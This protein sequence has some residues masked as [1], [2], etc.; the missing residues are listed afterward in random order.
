ME[1]HLQS[2]LLN[3]T[4]ATNIINEEVIQELWSGYGKILRVKL[5]GCK[6][7][8]LIVKHVDLNAKGHHPRGWNT[9][10]SHQRKIESYQVEINWYRNYSYKS[11]SRLPKCYGA[12]YNDDEILILLEDL[13]ESGFHLRKESLSLEEISSCLKW[14]AKFHS[15][16]LGVK[17]EG[18]WETGSYWHLDTRP[19]E[20]NALKDNRLKQAAPLIDQVLKSCKYQTL[21]HGDAKLANFCFGNSGDVAAVDFQYVGGGCGMKDVAYFIGSVWGEDKCEDYED[22][23]LDTYFSYLHD[24]MPIKNIELENEWREMYPYAWADFYRFLKGWSPEHWKLNRYSEKITEN[25][26]KKLGI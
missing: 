25:V 15:S 14:L 20:L 22:K 2:I 11:A 18:L 12:H 5:S 4:G 19:Q 13:N 26:L 21:I 10:I 6:I 17:P 23:I 16:F 24:E 3:S 8:S 7:N 1:Q 9:D